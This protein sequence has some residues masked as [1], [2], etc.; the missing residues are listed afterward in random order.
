MKPEWLPFYLILGYLLFQ[1]LLK[2]SYPVF[3]LIH[4]LG[5]A[6][7]ACFF[8]KK[9]V[10][11]HIGEGD[12]LFRF[13]IQPIQFELHRRTWHIGRTTYAGSPGN[14][15]EAVFIILSAPLLSLLLTLGFGYLLL[16]S[17]TLISV[18]AL[19][20]FCAAWLASFHITFSA[21]WPFKNAHSD[22][23]D[24]LTT[25]KFLRSQRP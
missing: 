11:I 5:H 9:Q 22:I 25:C 24:F 3:V 18:K 13:C 6:L 7:P 1:F 19:L 14:R 15:I 2:W 21:I 10:Q 17:G 16:T 20:L 12:S 4:E 23:R 8:G